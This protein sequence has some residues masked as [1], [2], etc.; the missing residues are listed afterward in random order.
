MCRILLQTV[1]AGHGRLDGHLLKSRRAKDEYDFSSKPVL[2]FGLLEYMS[3]DHQNVS[4][5]PLLQAGSYPIAPAS[6]SG[7]S[8]CS[9]T[10]RRI[11]S[12]E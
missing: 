5:A 2:D 9:S 7:L 3:I 8:I 12:S 1:L 10:N 6:N 11:S 4:Q